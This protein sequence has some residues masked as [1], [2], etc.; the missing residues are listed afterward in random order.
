MP[1]K[2]Q[3]KSSLILNQSF[4]TVLVLK[5]DINSAR[6]RDSK[7]PVSAYSVEKLR[8][9]MIIKLKGIIQ[10]PG[11]RITDQ[12]CRSE[13]RQAG[14]SC[15][16]CYPLVSTVLNA[17]QIANKIAAHF[18]TEFFNRI[19]TKRTSKNHD[20]AVA[21]IRRLIDRHLWVFLF[22]TRWTRPG[23]AERPKRCRSFNW[24]TI[25]STSLV[26]ALRPPCRQP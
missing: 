21:T 18:K 5:A 23:L 3:M 11:A 10:S 22:S 19:G 6:N 7:G 26:T 16:F 8:I 24:A 13:S 15:G 1:L 20:E 14:F 17:A 4:S 9:R 25:S 12:L 2:S